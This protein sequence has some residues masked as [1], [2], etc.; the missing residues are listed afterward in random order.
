MTWNCSFRSTFRLIPERGSPAKADVVDAFLSSDGCTKEEVLHS[1]PYDRSRSSSP[2]NNPSL[3]RYRDGRQL[4]RTVGLVYEET[5]GSES[6]IR[7][8]DFGHAV[9]RWRPVISARNAPVLGRYAASALAACQLRTPFREARSY[10]EHIRVFPFAFIW[11]AMLA[12]GGTITS[13]ELNRAVLSTEN[14]DDLQAAINRIRAARLEGDATILGEEVISERAKNDRILVWMAWASFGWTLID[15]KRTSGG[16]A[17]AI[18]PRADD[19][20]RDAARLKY[21]HREFG[22]ESEYV[23]Y[24][25]RC[26]GLP[27]DLR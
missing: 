6:R 13:D 2:G 4:L 23:R 21:E 11:R 24:I 14:E 22:T 5:E 18:S 1:L 15:D 26:A 3:K 16:D 8:T 27:E 9:R 10:G 17:Y 19:V 12:L 20:L 25:A 7:V